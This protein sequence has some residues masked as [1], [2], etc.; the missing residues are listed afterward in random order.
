MA[1][2]LDFGR[3]ADGVLKVGS[4]WWADRGGRRHGALDLGMPVGTPVR[5]VQSGVVIRSQ[6]T[7]SGDAGIWV[8]IQHPHLG[9]IITRYMHFSR[10]AVAE[11]A[12]VRKGQV[13]GYSGNT[14]SSSAP[15]LHFDIKAPEAML[16]PIA[17]AAGKPSTGWLPYQSGYG[18]GVPAEPWVP[19]DSYR[20]DTR[21]NAAKY[22]IPLYD[23]MPH[24]IVALLKLGIVGFIGWGA[25]K[26]SKRWRR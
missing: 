2:D 21:A 13:I 17:A 19:V 22:G 23:Q 25:W 24:G 14:G 7:P 12:V 11:G 20:D 10:V 15:H 6:A 5:A 3:P 26:L 9:G 16:V 1:A 4:G 8:A 18:Y